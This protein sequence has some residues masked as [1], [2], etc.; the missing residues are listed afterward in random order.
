MRTNL[1]LV[2]VRH[3]RL[4]NT[5]LFTS[6]PIELANESVPSLNA[7][8]LKEYPLAKMLPQFPGIITPQSPKH[9]TQHYN[10]HQRATIHVRSRQLSPDKLATA[11]NEFNKLLDFDICQVRGLPFCK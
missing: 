1:L 7:L 11:Q 6:T 2:D 5:Q 8:C 3:N 4:V 10:Q 9:S